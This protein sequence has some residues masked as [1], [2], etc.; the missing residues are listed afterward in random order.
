[1]RIGYGWILLIALSFAPGLNAAPMSGQQVT[2]AVETWLRSGLTESRSDARVIR[3]EPFTTDGETV[4][5]IAHLSRGGYC[6]CGADD[7][8]LP[9]NFYVPEG[10]YIPQDEDLQGILSE[11]ARRL[12]FV[13]NSLKDGDSRLD[14]YTEELEFRRREWSALSSGQILNRS[15]DDKNR[16]LPTMMKLPLNSSWHQGNP[17]YTYCPTLPGE[18]PAR[19]GCVATAMAQIM[20]YWQWPETGLSSN[21]AV[22][23]YKYSST[24]L[25]EPLAVDPVI[26]DSFWDSRLSWTSMDGGHLQ[27]SGYWDDSIYLR[28]LGD[29][30]TTGFDAALGALFVQL[31]PRLQNH[32]ADFAATSY[33]FH[34]MEDSHTDIGE[35]GSP[36]VAQLSYHAGI[37]V[38]MN[39]GYF[40]SGT[41]TAAAGPAYENH[42]KYDPDHVYGSLDT[43]LIIEE[44]QWLR[45]V[46]VRG[47]GPPGGHSWVV[48]GYDL[49][50]PTTPYFWM[51]MG[52]SNGI[53]GW[54]RFDFVPE[55]LTTDNEHVTG[56]APANV[57]RFLGPV[58]GAGADGSPANPFDN[59]AD[60]AAQTPNG[61]TIIIKAGT[62]L[63]WDGNGGFIDH[64]MT[65]KGQG[66]TISAQ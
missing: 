41:P 64:P 8:L 21:T 38:D 44:T 11:M 12:T 50:F 42:F 19:V 52:W 34:L 26:T 62:D 22:Y 14:P 32:S 13:Q 66:V 45:P 17:Y 47:E 63:I 4:A 16:A 33:N 43:D 9:V 6:I 3:L 55:D 24:W 15:V 53:I 59:L 37:A 40:G 2:T 7:V 31:S 48:S 54:Y 36:A 56:I 1:M 49:Y 30:N 35:A 5:Y 61:G 57:V 20:Y 39:W 18:A 58:A 28:A 65:I 29:W 60:A 27:I 51:N 25:T 46:Q 23:S 10:E